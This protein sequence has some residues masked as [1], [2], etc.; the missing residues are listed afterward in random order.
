MFIAAISTRIDRI[1]NI[2]LSSTSSARRNDPL[3]SCHV[4]TCARSPAARSS[5]ITMSSMFSGSATVTSSSSARPSRL[6]KL[7]ASAKGR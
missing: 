5:G 7:C 6:K 2:T 4:Q 1:T 3:A